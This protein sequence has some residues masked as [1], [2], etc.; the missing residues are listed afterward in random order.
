MRRERERERELKGAQKQS[1]IFP[2]T[3]KVSSKGRGSINFV[4][5]TRYT[6][7]RTA[8]IQ[9]NSVLSPL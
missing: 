1:N 8:L 5:S 2:L 7:R 9:I 3:P 6:S 4:V